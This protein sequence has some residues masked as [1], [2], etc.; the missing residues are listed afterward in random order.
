MPSSLF[1]VFIDVLRKLDESN[2]RPPVILKEQIKGLFFVA[3]I[4]TGINL[5]EAINYIHEFC[6]E[7]KLK[8]NVEKTMITVLKK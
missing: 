7:R 3:G 4:I 6:N 1:A 2:I 5:Q 8:I